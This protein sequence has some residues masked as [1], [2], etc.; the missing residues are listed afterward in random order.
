MAEILIVDQG[1]AE[2]ATDVPAAVAFTSAAEVGEEAID[3]RIL[4]ADPRSAARLV[5]RLPALRWIQSTWAGVDALARHGVP[6]GVV[7]TG[8]K[9]VFGPQMAEFVFAHLLAHSQRVV[10]RA[11]ARSWDPNPPAVLAGTRMG[12]LG[13][14]SIGSVVAGAAVRFGLDVVGCSRGGAP[15]DGFRQVLAVDRR[16]D[17]AAGLDHLVVVLPSTAETN[18]LVDRVM[19]EEM[20]PGATLI[21]VGRGNAVVEGDV[22]A[23]LRSGRLSL[24]VLDV[25]RREPLP[26]GDPLWEVDGLIVT[27]HTAAW[28][29]PADVARVFLDNLRRFREAEPLEGVI[30][31]ERGY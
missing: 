8:L 24:A 9:G 10:E 12:I 3:C 26:D 17:F 5:D 25:L 4:L 13:T 18:D 11:A 21:N 6:A 31:L 19:I 23:A 20:N 14:G 29:R 22:V 7:V 28:S 1:A 30:D 16:R 2:L 15:V 27:S